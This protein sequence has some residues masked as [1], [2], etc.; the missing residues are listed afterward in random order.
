MPRATREIRR[1]IRSVTNTRKVTKAMELVASAKMR[2]AV[3]AMLATRPYA[4]R[5]WELL[6]D[7]ASRT[8]RE[9]HGL[10]RRSLGQKVGLVLVSSNRGLVGGFNTQ[11]VNSLVQYLER[12]Q[13]SG[14]GKPDIVLLGKKGRSIVHK[15]GYP[16]V[17]E[18]AKLDVISRIQD[19]RPLVHLVINDFRSGKYD[20]IMMAYTDFIS[21]LVQKPQIRQLLPLEPSSAD[22]TRSEVNATSWR[23]EYL[24]EP[25]PDD[26]F[27][28]L[29]PR[30][31]EIQLFQAVLE[32]TAAEHASRMV[33]MRNASDAASDL[34]DD[35]T[36]S[37]NQARQAGITQ[38]L[39]EISASRVAVE[40]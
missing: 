16:A 1:R 2:R 31:V 30:L 12:E 9:A 35:L 17:A 5:A 4:K 25:N 37:F 32:S 38:D 23:G 33:A 27:E 14:G 29:L 20:R 3:Q 34:I 19:I 10:L 26:V 13:A 8:D 21:T 28:V 11:L 36:L 7:L 39:A 6:L 18:F 22:Q 15:Y 24:F 40:A